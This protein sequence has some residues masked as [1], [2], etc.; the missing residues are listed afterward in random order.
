MPRKINQDIASGE[1]FANALDEE[2]PAEPKASVKEKPVEAEPA[3]DDFDYVSTIKEIIETNPVVS[4]NKKLKESLK[5]EM[6]NGGKS[7]VETEYG[8]AK[9][10]ES[11]SEFVDEEGLKETLKAGG[12]GSYVKTR[13]IEYVD[14]DALESTIYNKGEG[15]IDLEKALKAHTSATITK[16]LTVSAPKKKKGE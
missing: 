8:V 1:L 9:I 10:S 11:E 12:F 2:K 15:S 6:Q 16:K 7:L 3:N 14:M 13:T 5:D 4:R